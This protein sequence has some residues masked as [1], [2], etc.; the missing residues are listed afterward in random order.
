M[1]LFNIRVGLRGFSK[2]WP[3]MIH[4]FN[5]RVEVRG[6]SEIRSGAGINM[7]WNEVNDFW[8]GMILLERHKC[9]IKTT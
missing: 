5:I 2:H 1:Y 8:N 3:G 4:L 9:V 7:L 6:E